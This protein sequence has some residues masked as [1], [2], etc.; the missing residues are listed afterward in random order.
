MPAFLN[1]GQFKKR[2]GFWKGK[3]R[4][5]FSQEWKDKISIARKGKKQYEITPEIR[6]KMSIAAKARPSTALG[7]HWK[8]SDEARK[9][10][11]EGHK[12]EKSWLWKGGVTPQTKMAR[13]GIDYREWRK[14]VF[15]RDDYRCY[16]CGERGKE[17]EA[18]HIYPFS[19]FPRLRL[20]VENGRTLCKECHRKSATWGMKGK[21]KQLLLQ[22][23]SS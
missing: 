13:M 20:M 21:T 10:I 16:D 12:G 19:L 14:A 8:L 6:M 9:N 11:S 23:Q 5:A 2:E 4:P 22:C 17:L 7:K 15:A 1:S 3:K 18:D